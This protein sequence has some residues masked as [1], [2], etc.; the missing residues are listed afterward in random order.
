M[1]TALVWL[2]VGASVY[3]NFE[4]IQRKQDPSPTHGSKWIRAFNENE[5]L[6][7]YV[8]ANVPKDTTLATQNPALV[9]LYTGHKTVASDDPA[10]AW[11][12]WKK[13]GVRYLVQTSPYALGNPTANEN[14]FRLAYRQEGA[15]NLRVLDLGE[16]AARPNW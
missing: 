14:K 10:S 9:H 3:S 1:A 6:I 5:A 12:N 13:L 11:E 4:F 7:Q 16:P 8:A 15:F 2:F